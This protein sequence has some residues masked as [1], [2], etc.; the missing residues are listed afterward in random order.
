[1]HILPRWIVA[2]SVAVALPLPLIPHDAGAQSGNVV[3]NMR[4]VEIA[5]VAQQ[6]S[7]ITGR[8]II[9]DPAVD[10]TINVTSATPLSPAAVWELFVSVL[11]GQGYA[12]VRTGRAWR[13]VPQAAA[14]RQPSSARA[15]G[16]IVTRLIRLNRLS[17]EAAARIFGPLVADFGSIEPVTNPNAIVV[18]D[19]SDNVARIASLAQSLDRGGADTTQGFASIEVREGSATDIAAAIESIMGGEEGG[20]RAVAD[21][22]SNIVLIRGTTA[23]IAEARRIVATLDRPSGVAPVVRVIRLRYNDAETITEIIGGLVG[24]QATANNPVARTLSGLGSGI[25]DNRLVDGV[26]P[27]RETT[28]AAGGLPTLGETPQ[29]AQALRRDRAIGDSRPAAVGFASETLSIQAAPDLNAIVIRGT[30]GEVASIETLITELD[31][32]RPQVMIEAA[33]VEITGD[34]SEQLGIQLGL[35]GAADFPVNS[36]GTSFS[37]LGLSLRQALGI[38][39]APAAAALGVDGIS[40]SIGSRGDFAILVQALGQSSR[41]NLLSTPSITTLDNQPAEIV[42]GQNVPFRTGSFVSQGITTTPFTTIERADVG[43][44]LRV[45]P[46]I[47]EGE[48]VRLE[49]SQEVSSLVG[50]VSGA[51]DIITNRRSI[52]TSVLADDGQTI[53]LGGLISDDRLEVRSKV[54]VLGDIPIV[55][56]LFRSRRELETRR[57]LFVFLKPTILRDPAA[58]ADAA[59]EKYDELRRAEYI[60]GV[61]QSLLLE[62]REIRLPAEIDGVY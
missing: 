50:S 4:D 40:G 13:V 16:Q 47:H 14:I 30:P 3:V 24:G 55:G 18:T 17:P 58:V 48:T 60:N 31:V 23:Q 29:I 42:V 8:T 11:R 39:G 12:V 51:A 28:S 5:D 32:R 61:D 46:R 33:I 38:V 43:I 45:V 22:R 9:L 54:P 59:A 19:Y 6:I 26:N 10:G 21:E 37:N 53:V 25:G 62:P 20:P 52:Q 34:Q 57:T 35:G 56:N 41:A 7:R 27:L 49:V 44:T 2:A 1:M 15:G 36:G